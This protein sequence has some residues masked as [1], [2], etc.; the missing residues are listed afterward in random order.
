M[1]ASDYFVHTTP[2]TG[3]ANEAQ[4]KLPTG[5]KPKSRYFM[6]ELRMRFSMFDSSK[7]LKGERVSS[8][9]EALKTSTRTKKSPTLQFVITLDCSDSV[10]AN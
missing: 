6:N 1:K 3:E 7:L 8:P 5:S 4:N 10:F 2:N 9:Q